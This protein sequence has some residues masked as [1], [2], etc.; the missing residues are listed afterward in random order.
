M[1][2]DKGMMGFGV[3]GMDRLDYAVAGMDKPGFEVVGLGRVV[4]LDKIVC[5]LPLY[6]SLLAS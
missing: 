2:V 3:V 4:V 5:F 1:V 6:L